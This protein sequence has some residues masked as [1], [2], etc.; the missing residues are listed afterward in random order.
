MVS[1]IGEYTLALKIF[2]YFEYDIKFI[3][4]KKGHCHVGSLS[5]VECFVECVSLD[6]YFLYLI[7]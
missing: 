1:K 5:C 7:W 3:T 6:M 4:V 2:Y